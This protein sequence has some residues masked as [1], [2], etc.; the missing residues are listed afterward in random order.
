MQGRKGSVSQVEVHQITS[1]PFCEILKQVIRCLSCWSFTKKQGERGSQSKGMAWPLTPYSLE[2]T[3]PVQCSN[4][5]S[6]LRVC[7]MR[8]LWLSIW[9]AQVLPDSQNPKREGD[10]GGFVMRWWKKL[11]GE[12]GV[13][14]QLCHTEGH[15][16]RVSTTAELQ[17]NR[18]PRTRRQE[19]TAASRPLWIPIGWAA[20]R[21]PGLH[22]SPQAN[23]RQPHLKLKTAPGPS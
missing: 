6:V 12:A 8:F 16:E 3:L 14:T 5:W 23:G 2:E 15:S 10:A 1:Y 11:P 18:T 7:S 9:P 22:L 13:C 4:G 21:R 17:A 20:G 19:W